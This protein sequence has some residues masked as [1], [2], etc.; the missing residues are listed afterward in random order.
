MQH[1]A[2][3]LPGDRTCY[4]CGIKPDHPVH[5]STMAASAEARMQHGLIEWMREQLL[6]TLEIAEEHA[7]EY[8]HDE[9]VE[10]C[11]SIRRHLNRSAV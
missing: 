5:V 9:D 6:W 2:E 10:R 4:K 7:D 1:L 8:G 11:R 3:V